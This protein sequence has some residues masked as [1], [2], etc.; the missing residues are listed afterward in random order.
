VIRAVWN[1]TR[2]AAGRVEPVALLASPAVSDPRNSLALKLPVWHTPEHSGSVSVDVRWI[3]L[4]GVTLL[5]LGCG[6]VTSTE[7]QCW[8]K[9]IGTVRDFSSSDPDFENDVFLQNALDG[10][11]Y[12]PYTGLVQDKLVDGLPALAS[13]TSSDGWQMITSAETFAQWFSRQTPAER[14]LSFDMNDGLLER[15]SRDDFMSYRTE[16]FFPIDD[17]ESMEH[18]FVDIDGIEHNFHF[19]FELE[20]RFVYK[21]GEQLT[22]IGDDDIWIFINDTL[23]IDLGGLHRGVGD[24]IYLDDL[25]LTVGNEYPLA[26]FYAERHTQESH[27]SLRSSIHHSDCEAR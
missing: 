24:M 17:L 1:P 18:G 15:A 3:G 4:V 12:R 13:T 7:D 26:L 20:A 8:P 14:T 9:L 2:A 23:A 10:S 16:K 5:F 11:V 21:G 27:F 19:T 25:G 6:S 22:F